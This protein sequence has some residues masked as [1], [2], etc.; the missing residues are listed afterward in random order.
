MAA[1]GDA[2]GLAAFVSG[3][4]AVPVEAVAAVPEGAALGACHVPL[5]DCAAG[6][7]AADAGEAAGDAA[8]AF[9]VVLPG[10]SDLAAEG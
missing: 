6:A 5:P 3:C 7:G 2:G 9:G 1:A 8:A 10:V 4:A